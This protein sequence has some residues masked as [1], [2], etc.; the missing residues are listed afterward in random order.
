MGESH[1]FQTQKQTPPQ[2][3]LYCTIIIL[4]SSM[5]QPLT[6]LSNNN[7]TISNNTTTGQKLIDT[8]K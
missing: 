7:I 4:I 8:N 2:A 1:T 3:V 5:V 6:E